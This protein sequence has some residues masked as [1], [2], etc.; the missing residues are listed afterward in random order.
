MEDNWFGKEIRFG[1]KLHYVNKLKLILY[2]NCKL[3]CKEIDFVNILFVNKFEFRI[4]NNTIDI[5]KKGFHKYIIKTNSFEIFC[6]NYV[7][8]KLNFI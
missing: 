8:I 2:K 7:D 3:C 5:G 1:E 6:R 4:W